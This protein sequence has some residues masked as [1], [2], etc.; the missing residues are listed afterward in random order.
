MKPDQPDVRGDRRV[1]FR[2]LAGLGLAGGAGAL[3]MRGGA[4]QAKASAP[5][6]AAADEAGYRETSH[7]RKYYDTARG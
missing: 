5:S 3:L 1:F 4:V 2:T 7:I 6:A